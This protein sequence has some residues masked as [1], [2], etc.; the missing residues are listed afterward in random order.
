MHEQGPYRRRAIKV[1]LSVVLA[2]PFCGSLL[3]LPFW[4]GGEK[5]AIF[6]IGAAYLVGLGPALIAGTL[7]SYRIYRRGVISS[8]QVLKIA[9]A[10]GFVSLWAVFSIAGLLEGDFSPIYRSVLLALIVGSI[11]TVVALMFMP[12]LERSRL[13]EEDHKG[14]S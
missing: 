6:T 11:S 5:A 13:L 3:F 8:R 2:G 1:F 12:L 14:R 7:L 4:F 10:S 9:F